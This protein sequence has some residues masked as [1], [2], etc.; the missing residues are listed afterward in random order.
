MEIF[1][2]EYKD[3]SNIPFEKSC[4]LLSSHGKHVAHLKALQIVYKVLY[5]LIAYGISVLII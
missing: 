5:T 4:L 3:I 2:K 1:F